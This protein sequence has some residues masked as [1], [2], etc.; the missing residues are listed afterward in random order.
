MIYLEEKTSNIS[1]LIE[2]QFPQYV[3]ENNEKFLKFLSSYYE[4]QELKYKPLD[5]ASNLVDY[6]NISYFRP[7]RLIESTNIT[8]NLFLSTTTVKVS[9]T[10]GFP[11]ENGYIQID[12][13][14][15]FYRTKTSTTFDDCVRGTTALVL[16]Q[17]PK[18]DLII[19]NSVSAEHKKNSIVKNLAFPY[20]NEFLKRIKS[21]LAVLIPE[22]L[23]E[24]LD[25]ASFIKNIKSF[26]SSKGSL[27]GH[28]IL[29]RILF[30]DRKFNI[31]LKNRGSGA[32]LKINNFNGFIPSDPKPQI[33]DGGLNYDNR[34]ENNVLINP[35]L[36]E[37]FGSGT[38]SVFPNGTRP[39]A[40]AIIEV[41][42][43]DSNGSITDIN[44]EDE[45]TGYRGPITARVR[46]RNF[47]QDQL[48]Y[49][50]DKSASGRV[51]YYDGFTEELI[52]YDVVGFFRP[53]EEI[54]AEGG[55]KARAFIAQS[56]TTPILSR[57]GV[58]VIGE[59][60]NIE[61]P[62][63]YTFKTSN[64]SFVEKKIIRCKL[65][66]G[67]NIPPQGLP[68]SFVLTQDSD[69]LFG[70]KGTTISIDNIFFLSDN[71]YEFEIST[72]KNLNSIY[73]PPSTV[74]T[75]NISNI[76]AN[77]PEFV[78]TVDS[79]IGFPVTN[80]IIN[81]KGHEIKY[82][83]RSSEQFF[84]C[85]Y[86]GTE[87]FSL[88][89]KDEVISFGRD[90]ITTKW[91]T[92]TIVKKGDY[93]VNENKIYLAESSGIT[94]ASA[95]THSTGSFYD[96]SLEQ[97][98]PD[99]VLWKFYGPNKFEYSLYID[100]KNSLIVNPRFQLL[101][102]P[103]GVQ[104]ISGGSLHID[105]KFKF[106]T[107]DSPNVDVYNFTTKEISDRLALVLGTNYN[108][109]RNT[110]T[111]SRFPSY[112]SLVGFNTQYDYGD[113]IYV[114]SSGIPRW[115]D[116]IVD[117]SQTTLSSDDEKKISFTNQKLLSRWKKSSLIYETQAVGVLRKT[118]KLVGLNIDAIQ[119]N[120]YKGNTIEYGTINKF[121][122]GDGGVYPVSYKNDNGNIVV[123]NNLNPKFVLVSSDGTKTTVD[124]TSKLTKIS[125]KITKIN[126]TKLF[127]AWSSNQN[128]SEFTFKPNIEVVN[129]NP[130][131]KLNFTDY[132]SINETLKEITYTNHGL[133]TSEKVKLESNGDYFVSL[134]NGSEYF[135]SKINDDVFTLHK[136]KSDSL[137]GKNAVS[138]TIKTVGGTFAIS[139]TSD[140]FGF[141]FETEIK[142][143]IGFK[144]ANL[145]L[146]FKNGK[147]DNILIV[148]SGFGYVETPDIII[149]GGGKLDSIKIPFSIN[150]ETIVEMEGS[151]V[152]YTNFYK[153]NYNE[154]D[155]FTQIPN[156]FD[157]PPK[158]EVN[159]G[160]GAEAIAYTTNGVIESVVLLNQGESYSVPPKVVITGNGKD[161]VIESVID[162]TGKVIEF[163]I[164]NPGSGYTVA[165]R[166]D[167]V[168]VGGGSIVSSR[169]NE[170][171]FNMVRQLNKTGRI[172]SYGG[173]VYDDSD[174]TPPTSINP[175]K[176]LQIN[177]NLDF[178]KDLDRKQYFLLQNSDKLL[179]KYIEEKSPS[180]V[181][182]SLK[183][184][185]LAINPNRNFN[186]DPLTE[187][188]LFSIPSHSPAII[189]SYDGVPV[190]G[191]KKVYTVR[192]DPSQGLS[193]IK[194]RYK[195]KYTEETSAVAGSIT[196]N[197]TSGTKYVTL[198]RP[199]GPSV[200]EYPIG[201][202]IEDYEYVEG[203]DNDLDI[204]NGRF[205]ITPEFPNGR[206]CYFTTRESYDEI[207]N[208]LVEYG[209]NSSIGFNG[210]PYF[211]GD[212]FAS[213]YDDYMNNRCRTN[214]KIP[215]QFIRSF[216]KD[217][218]PLISDG[219]AYFGGLPEG[220]YV[221]NGLSHNDEYP[222]EDTDIISSIVSTKTI[223]PGSVDSVIIESK[224]DGYRVGDKLQ[225]DNTLTSGTGFAGFVSKVGGKNISN[226]TKS[227]NYK[228]V[229]FTT[230][231]SNGLKVGDYIYFD[232][233]QSG[234]PIEINLHG[235]VASDAVS[236]NVIELDFI[237]VALRENQ[238]ITFFENK[239]IFSVNLNFKFSYILNIFANSNF[240][241]TYDIESVNEFFTLEE[242]PAN[243]VKLTSSN[244]PNR[245]YLHIID[246]GLIYEINKTT[247][248]YG[249]HRIKSVDTQKNIFSVEFI[250]S[251]IFY[252]TRSLFYN[253]KSYG[254][255]GPI[256]EISI[257]S[258]GFN[259][260]K[261]PTIKN[262]IKKGTENEQAGNGKAIIQANSNTIGKIKKVVYDSIGQSFTSS[263]VVNHYLNIP[264]TA[265]ITNN[266]EIYDVELIDGGNNYDNVVEILVNGKSGIANIKATVKIGTI[267][268]LEVI[269]GGTNFTEEPIL[270]V[271]STYGS[272][273]VLKAKIR[274][275]KIYADEFLSGSINSSLFPIKI[276]S[277]VVNFDVNTSTLEFDEINGQ[278][279]EN[280]TLY[281]FDGRPYGNIVSIR[282]TR[283][284]AKVSPYATLDSERSD[285]SG[286]TSEYLQKITDSNYYQDWSYS[287]TSSR[288]TIEW[289]KQQDVN[290]HP[291]GFRQFGKK[292]I[293]RRKFFFDNP[294]DVFKSSVIFT[295]N[296]V[297]LI[298]LKVKL[299][300]C[301][302]QKVFLQD[303]SDFEVGDYFY[304]TTSTAI[305]EVIEKTLY[306]VTFRIRTPNKF[307]L[308]EILL[309]ITP[310]FAF[311][312]FTDTDRVLAFYNGVFQEPEES[313]EIATN[314]DRTVQNFVPKFEII[315]SDEIPLYKLTNQFT[316]IDG[317]ILN[318]TATTF[319]LSS[320]G[321]PVSIDN[322]TLEQFII[323]IGGSVQN[324]DNLSVVNN[325]VN[326]G[327]ASGYSSRVFG[328]KSQNLKKLSFTGSG[329]TYTINYTPADDCNLLI[330]HEGAFQT[331]LLT[332]FTVS[333]NTVTFSEPVSSGNIFGWYIDEQV[334][335]ELL[336]TSN[337]DRN[338]IFNIFDCVTKN[339]TQFIESNS[340]KRPESLYEIRREV[341]DGTVYPVDSTTVRGFN[342]N[343]SYTS[344]KYSSS[345]VEVLDKINFDGSTQTFNL[346]Y[347]GDIHNPSNGEES[348]VVYLMDSS[349]NRI[350]LDH[351]QYS[352]SGSTITF[353][354]IYA[355]SISCTIL[356]F[357]SE[358]S[359]NTNNENGTIIDR[360]EVQQNSTRKIFNLSDRGVPKYVNNVGDIF[361]IENGL[362][363]IPTNSYVDHRNITLTSHTI[364]DN[365]ITFVTAPDASDNNKLAFFNRQLLPEPS[366]NVILDR[367]R[368]FD[369]IRTSFPI[370]TN[371]ILIT[372]ISV[373][374]LF[375]IRN[376]VM[377]KPGIDYT[378]SGGHN[379]VFSTAP[380]P[381][382]AGLIFAFYSYDGLNQN[383]PLNNP[384]YFNG[385]SNSFAI[386]Q[387]YQST[388]VNSDHNALVFRNGVYQY[389][390][391]DYSINDGQTAPYITFATAP[392]ISDEIFITNLKQTLVD[393]TGYFSQLTSNQIQSSASP[394]T[395]DDSL[396]LIFI[397]GLLQVG[398]SWS[399]SS[400]TITFNAPVSLSGDTVK[401]YAF[402]NTKRE[403]DP[404]NITN[405]SVLTYNLDYNSTQISNVSK[406]SDLIVSIE[407]VVQEPEVAYTV[408]SGTITFNTTAL[409]QTGVDI[410]I[411]QVGDNTSDLTERI[412]YIDDNYNK[413]TETVGGVSIKTNR[414]KLLNGFQSFNPPNQ[415]DL[416]IIRNGV[417]QNP[418]ED[419]VSGNGFIEFTT[420]ITVDDDLFILYTHGSEELT[421]LNDSSVS[422]SVHRYTVSSTITDFNDIIVYADGAPRFY[423]RGD[424]T[425]NGSDID[426]T[427][428]DG[429]VP[430]QVFI[431]KY[432]NVMVIDDFEDCPNG[433]RTRFK[434]LYNNQ[435]LN[436]SNTTNNADILVSING[437][438]L[439]PGTEYTLTA[440]RGFIDMTNPPQ[441][442]DEIFM[443]RMLGNEVRNFTPNGTP[444]QYT[445]NVAESTQK[446]NIVVFSNNTWK[447][448]ELGDFTWINDSTI[449]LNTPH[450]SGN[451]FGIKFYGVFN[452]LDQ[453][454]TPY[455]GSNTEFNLYDGEENFVPVGTTTNDNVPDE[456]SLLIFKNSYFLDPKVDFTLIGDIKSRL[457]FA[458]APSSSDVISVRSVGSFLKLDT[459]NNGSGNEFNMT[460]NGTDYYPNSDIERPRKLENQ[461]MVIID[462]NVMSPL[463]D[464]F[465][466]NNKIVF[467][468]SIASFTKMVILD[469]RGT[470]EDV[471]VFNRFNQVS[472]GDNLTIVGEDS[473][474]KVTQILSPTVLKTESYTG[475]SPRDFQAST[476][477]SGSGSI[478]SIII[479]QSGLDFKDPVAIITE[480]TGE[481]ATVIG[482]TNQ[483]FGG[484]V[485][486]GEFLYPGNNVYNN[487]LVYPTVYASVYKEQPLHKSQIR[488]A[489]KLSNNI[490]DSVEFIPLANTFEM[491]SNTPT[492]TVSSSSG[493]NADFK[494]YIS[495]GE[496]RKIEILNSGSGYDDRDITI[497]LTGG[498][499][500]GC[501]LEPVLDG[502]GAF[503]D[504]IIR[505]PGVGYDTNRV[506]IYNEI[507]GIV[508]A[509]VI[510]YT[511][512]TSTGID[513]C[514]RGVL[515]TASSH[516]QD[517][518]VYFDNYL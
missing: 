443:V 116:D 457:S 214:D 48:V 432:P 484:A 60:Q 388:T 213:E 232:Y 358:F 494:V 239:R 204:H 62:R 473:P 233:N 407:G 71:I 115:W 114:A 59:K 41:T 349:G 454:H 26:Y 306:S 246:E 199:G 268:G 483:Y 308:N 428:T 160:F 303:S 106:A 364:N 198:S 73:L 324:P 330:F 101:A 16:L 251:T 505:N 401:I 344:P 260:R 429:I 231:T 371:G 450:T 354:S 279:K 382:E 138:V 21:E 418:T 254:A 247:D 366:K 33:V 492:V 293:E 31:K 489:T 43:I 374:H 500:T 282:R 2:N 152:S 83:T 292:I 243:T 490:N 451:L 478:S 267:T 55:E 14:I 301:N 54:I 12:D 343:F 514:T 436:I 35:P 145:D 323:S 403:L 188:E 140:G 40:T 362:L 322:S 413:L 392:V 447:F 455:N 481:V 274:R 273:A 72:Y 258:V 369:G 342:T 210:F 17:S 261:L 298:K 224:G 155:T 158:V 321:N 290:T 475:E 376:G 461:I 288:D 44:V 312:L 28:R 130:K 174:A 51:D 132:A 46:P 336:D 482:K 265:K 29:F 319:S 334:T 88:G 102:M 393:A 63:D 512:V 227:L 390:V 305:G 226:I 453:I 415:D 34:K 414:Y 424:F 119:V 222:S 328:I 486:D 49:N 209:D 411:Y 332:D 172:D 291:A 271:S 498:G 262:I 391:T 386:T 430:T 68:D 496:L 161:G 380:E 77:T 446:E 79:A 186:T 329:T 417:V 237:E 104:I 316:I 340:I 141:S 375:V 333:G 127:D 177:Y 235:N 250:E 154:I 87:L 10:K 314:Y 283:A 253:A 9:S 207:T 459:I 370:T 69:E 241:L 80:G 493:S 129:K 56:Y 467:N 146:S 221:F 122:I 480:G 383:I 205:S 435:N 426:L 52:L 458:T 422:S 425:V 256:E 508:N 248:Y 167:I 180:Y 338:K 50:L 477:L 123:D 270:T 58:E 269:D 126:F 469:F 70:V 275:K 169:L 286:N 53:N 159:N 503:T 112:Q 318:D 427:H 397:N 465:I 37:V 20:A 131:V 187:S 294:A 90:K 110:V 315:S 356:D 18:S 66:N 184:Q 431:I 183:Q 347:N 439:H 299:S 219:S 255:S 124:N 81:V 249:P 497:E 357:I 434:L 109:S 488:K 259:Y 387:N 163:K 495:G 30:N 445:I 433:T 264:S 165:P 189:V 168:P 280:D 173:Y 19:K 360:L 502:S 410:Y 381:S 510:E 75:K 105:T 242:S 107:Y 352:V 509:E 284:Y 277:K 405:T 398:T 193:E 185:L 485:I 464:Y 8:E 118:K 156:I 463:Y 98:D 84:G 153:E 25:I 471:K 368:C 82:K 97:G 136:T 416:M 92:G 311:G 304:G 99:P 95:P 421:I 331:Y 419:F 57:T 148:D 441:F 64:S 348:V 479:S 149:S 74:I 223:S 217:V 166:L 487:H 440:N 491:P 179:A 517:D 412:D 32:K 120:S 263:S 103:G 65:I 507:G 67:F 192:N 297:D 27:N 234:D 310:E 400:N 178:P 437:I 287:I 466:R 327:E 190:Y 24:S 281:L 409:Y 309:K 395:Y 456:T 266:F 506:I 420:N 350:V 96:G 100:Y 462:G 47:S 359:S 212:V 515:G 518:K 93:V 139:S 196:L 23:D 460:L 285:I 257:S 252:E 345:Y 200:S 272:G 157:A 244:I 151:L 423:Q 147:I 39:N 208:A 402:I 363:K 206:Y 355:A 295:T 176:F 38:G 215:S 144:N 128:L 150:G 201:T 6:Y 337:L 372:P 229:N 394:G 313:Y 137:T 11:E 86:E 220:E 474:R 4:S 339:F 302:V 353:N 296:I 317:Q 22:V 240:K 511:Y 76:T 365:K 13:E 89:I 133:E 361:A 501:V 367:F 191:G 175:Q 162:N 442:N 45:G 396:F 300:P 470:A 125:S 121:F 91:I 78:I 171:T 385:V 197:T 85:T 170:W 117:L 143:P 452:L 408:T 499:G 377:Q 468:F 113:Y 111:D 448:A 404:I 335:C 194:S 228:T 94:G 513:G 389:P 230:S 135:V 15:I 36:I 444:N 238:P 289:K 218:D 384:T 378:I 326:I 195:L 406:A 236:D 182:N 203:S 202:F 164:I 341:I 134:T 108:K 142:N 504:V 211:I 438:V 346:K 1:K 449:Q 7:N 373:N 5:I 320:D 351:D 42:D 472:V 216:E 307:V 61:F 325:I 516:S 278:F 245:L 399:Y 276:K 379:L 476:T 3:Q 181:I 225:V